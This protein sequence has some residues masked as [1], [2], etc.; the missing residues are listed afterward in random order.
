MLRH[1]PLFFAAWGFL[2]LA[3][4]PSLAQELWE[5]ECWDE[6]PRTLFQWSGSSE[7]G[8]PPGFDEPLA[9]DRPDFTEA[10][11]TV[12]RG[13]W[14]LEM[15]YTYIRDEAGTTSLSAHSY[16]ELLLRVGILADWLEARVGWNYGSSRERV[17]PLA[18]DISG[19][20][21]I[22]LGL[23]LG[24][25]PQDGIL[26][27][28]AIMPQMTVP[29]G[30]SQITAERVLPGVNWLYGWEMNDFLSTGGS[31]QANIAVDGETADEYLEFAQSWT[32]GYSLTERLGAY[33]EWFVLA[34]C[35]AETA[36][37]EHY[38]DAGFTFSVSNDLQFDVRAGKGISGP[39]DDYF[40]GTG[41]VIRW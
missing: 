29:T 33:T 19:A 5:G 35:G 14:Q 30:H 39:A 34:P 26:P 2:S 1:L 8:G 23:K 28:M 13:V 7:T 4:A 37:T 6:G 22:Y 27:E 15:G 20:E 24:L 25:T 12:G 11:T 9:S 38:L 31:T 18:T 36:A 21:D 10:S 32:I 40:L 41:A 17:G 3:A 16:P